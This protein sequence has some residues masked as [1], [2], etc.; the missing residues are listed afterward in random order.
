MQRAVAGGMLSV[1]NTQ[2]KGQHEENSGEPAG[3][4][5]QHIGGLSAKNILSHSSAKSRAQTLAL[6][7]LHQDDKGHQHRDQQVDGEDDVDEN[8]HFRGDQYPQITDFVNSH[9]PA[10]SFLAV[11]TAKNLT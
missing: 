9:P 6:R 11:Q 10:L 4:F 2:Y 5:H 7:A 1:K 3:E 8:V